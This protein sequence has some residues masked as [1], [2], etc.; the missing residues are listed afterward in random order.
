L[1][2]IKQYHHKTGNTAPF[3][4]DGETETWKAKFV[5][6]GSLDWN[7]RPIQALPPK[8]NILK[9]IWYCLEFTVEQDLQDKGSPQSVFVWPIR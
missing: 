5:I 1:F 4:T 6:G 2:N 8:K 7:I 3:L 9:R